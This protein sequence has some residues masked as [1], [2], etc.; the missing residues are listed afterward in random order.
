MI[1][2]RNTLLD[3]TKANQILLSNSSHCKLL[4]KELIAAQTRTS[5]QEVKAPLNF[6]QM[7]IVARSQKKNQSTVVTEN[8]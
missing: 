1:P 5:T 7:R 8:I 6:Q 3:I 2:K 4:L